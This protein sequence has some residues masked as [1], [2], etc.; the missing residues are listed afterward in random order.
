MNFETEASF[1][2]A[3]IDYAELRG[4]RVY[5]VPDSRK[6]QRTG[7]GFPDLVMARWGILVFAELKTDTGRLSPAQL[8]WRDAME[9]DADFR[10]WRPKD[11]E[12][13]KECLE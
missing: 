7:K 2:S 6:V 11:W 4:W 9:I 1:Q 5:H 8:E 3:V 12:R 10:V 13:I